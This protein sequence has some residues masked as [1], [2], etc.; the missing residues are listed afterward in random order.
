M[1]KLEEAAGEVL[2]WTQPCYRC[3][4]SGQDQDYQRMG[5]KEACR[6]CGGYGQ[7]T[8]GDIMEAI[9]HLKEALDEPATRPPA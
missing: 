2:A 1:S 3:E 9:F 5:I 8:F 7:V 6:N 4:G